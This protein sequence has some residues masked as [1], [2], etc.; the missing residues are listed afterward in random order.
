MSNT[1]HAW[2]TVYNVLAD[3]KQPILGVTN[4]SQLAGDIVAALVREGFNLRGGDFRE[5]EQRAGVCKCG[6]PGS[7]HNSGG[8]TEWRHYPEDWAG[9]RECGCMSYRPQA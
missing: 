9:R 1:D 4:R 5:V 3:H 7:I 8:C 6:H 2:N